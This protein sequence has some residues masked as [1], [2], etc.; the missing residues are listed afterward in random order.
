M[1]PSKHSITALAQI[2]KLIPRNLIPKLAD[3]YGVTEK[4]RSFT[5]TSHILALVYAQLSHS[6]GLN[7]VCDSLQNHRGA[8][9]S[10]RESV[11]PSR[12]GLSHANR[13][14]N[15]DMAEALFWEVLADMHRQFPGFGFSG[16]RNCGLPRRFKRT[17]NIVDS[18]TIALVANCMDWAQHRH[19]KAAFKMH[20]RLDLQ[21]FLPKFVLVKAANTHDITEAYEA[22]AGLSAGEIVVFDKAYL[23]FE[24]LNSLSKRDVFW[25]TRAKDNTQYEVV[26]QHSEPKGNIIRDVYVSLTISKTSD[27]YP[28][29]I[30]LV[31]SMVEFDGKPM[32]MVFLTNNMKWAPSSICDLYKSRW[33]IEVFFKEIKQTLQIADFM[34]YNEIAVR[35]QVWTALLVYILLRFISWQGKW[36]HSFTRLFTVLRGVLW[37]CLDMFSVISCCGTARGCTRLRAAPY[38]L[39]LPGFSPG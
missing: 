16:R 2:F 5:A 7:D 6:I 36:K 17:I 14:R 29:R 4:C 26:G 24:L 28:Q 19:R 38:Q 30:R 1:N 34:G 20:L 10:I 33:G 25:V 3:K 11:P 9:V 27:L 15:A 22:C 8:L 39:Y 32:Q 13:V 12:N 23:G 21:T 35:W 37:S 31:E 18:S